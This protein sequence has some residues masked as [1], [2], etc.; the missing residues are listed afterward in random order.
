[1][2]AA[3]FLAACVFDSN[4][5]GSGEK[6]IAPGFYRGDHGLAT[7]LFGLESALILDSNGSF[8]FFRIDSN[9]VDHEIKGTWRAVADNMIW[10]GILSSWSQYTG[11]FTSWDTLHLPDTS[12]LRNVTGMG[13]QRLEV[14]RDSTGNSSVLW[15]QYQRTAP[16]PALPDGSYE[17]T[18][19]FPDYTDITQNQ[20]AT[21]RYEVH[22]NGAFFETDILNSLPQLETQF[23]AW[24]EVGP[25]L[26][27]N[28]SSYRSADSAG[29][30]GPWNT[31]PPEFEKVIYL[32]NV[33]D[34]SFQ[35]WVPWDFS[36][37][38]HPYWADFHTAP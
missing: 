12:L 2:A 32:R 37:L 13:F 25:F 30:F 19:T 21:T 5:N 16:E 6:R 24:S 8:R 3:A 33:E 31:Y 9:A 36:N 35:V 28:H 11:E 4:E 14:S 38:D 1:M 20:F 17:Y 26:I 29:Q 10:N 27:A 22:R 18:D 34:S 23:A 7:R 15:V